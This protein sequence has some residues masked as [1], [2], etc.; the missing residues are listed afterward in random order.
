MKRYEVSYV[1]NKDHT[2]TYTTE[3]GL[4]INVD[5]ATI[6][7]KTAM[8]MANE[9]RSRLK[10]DVQTG[11]TL[12]PGEYQF[13]EVVLNNKVSG[14]TGFKSGLSTEQ[15]KLYDKLRPRMSELI[16]NA[17]KFGVSDDLLKKQ[18][19]VEL[20]SVEPVLAELIATKAFELAK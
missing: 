10:K 20:A 15:R 6:L 14:G 11:E 16:S 5:I 8:N 7:S 1:V 13:E 9:V 12:E 2:V 17:R 19:E 4:I 3:D 18:V